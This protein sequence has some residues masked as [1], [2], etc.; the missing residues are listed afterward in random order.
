MKTNLSLICFTQN[1]AAVST[2]LLNALGEDF[3][4]TGFVRS[5]FAEKWEV[6][7][8][9]VWGGSLHDWT[10]Q[11]FPKSD[12]LVFVGACGIAVRAIAPFAADKLHDP[13]VVVIDE[14]GRFCIPLLSGHVGRANELAGYFATILGALPVI[15]TATDLNGLFAVD[16]FA[17]KN[18]LVLTDRAK[19]KAISAAL[20]AGQKVA[21]FSDFPILGKLPEGVTMIGQNTGDWRICVSFRN[22]DRSDTLWLPPRRLV[23]G[24]GCRKGTLEDTIEAFVS[25]ALQ[26]AGVP[27]EALCAVCSIDLKKEEAGLIGFCQSHHLPLTTYSAAQ[28]REVPGNFSPS[29]FVKQVTGVDNVC[30]RAAVLGAGGGSLLLPKQAGSGV[31]AALAMEKEIT[32]SFSD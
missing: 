3:A 16:V 9:T 2:R 7:D 5:R 25:A 17:Q 19:A 31:T 28:L 4:A 21:L 1:G 23:L 18:G 8:L 32:L 29:G 22:P 27:L 24:I 26:K 6:P 14:K 30:E 13:A 10:A 11:Q 20:L 15:T 12:C